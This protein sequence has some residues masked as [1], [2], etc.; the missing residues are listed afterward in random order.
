[1]SD[2]DSPLNGHFSETTLYGVWTVCERVY[3]LIKW[4]SNYTCNG[5]YFSV[6]NSSS[7]LV[8]FQNIETSAI[9]GQETYIR[10]DNQRNIKSLIERQEKDIA[11]RSKLVDQYIGRLQSLITLTRES[12]NIFADVMDSILNILPGNLGS[13]IKRILLIVALIIVVPIMFFIG[14]ILIKLLNLL[15]WCD[16]PLIAGAIR[17]V[18]ETISLFSASLFGLRD[19]GKRLRC[20]KRKR[21]LNNES[22]TVHYRRLPSENVELKVKRY[23]SR[24]K[25]ATNKLV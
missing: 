9:L 25:K 6:P 14:I 21:G 19:L 7:N 2:V 23:H 20:Y 16:R 11:N 13:T 17:F 1:M 5:V 24:T 3:F 4:G 12:S 22:S 18:R 10:S 15:C 8:V